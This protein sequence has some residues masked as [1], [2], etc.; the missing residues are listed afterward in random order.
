[1][2][3][4]VAGA[5]L[6][7]TDLADPAL[8]ALAKLATRERARVAPPA[9]TEGTALALLA[10]VASRRREELRTALVAASQR[11]LQETSRDRHGLEEEELREGAAYATNLPGPEVRA[12]KTAQRRA[13]VGLQTALGNKFHKYGPYNHEHQ[14]SYEFLKDLMQEV[15]SEQPGGARA[16]ASLAVAKLGSD[17]IEALEVVAEAQCLLPNSLDGWDSKRFVA[18]LPR[19]TDE[20]YDAFLDKCFLG[21][22]TPQDLAEH[23][24][25]AGI[26]PALVEAWKGG[27]DNL[28]PEVMSRLE[29]T[30]V[31]FASNSTHS[32]TS[33]C[34]LGLLKLRVCSNPSCRHAGSVATVAQCLRCGVGPLGPADK[35]K[36]GGAAQPD[37]TAKEQAALRARLKEAQAAISEGEHLSAGRTSPRRSGTEKHRR[38]EEEVREQLRTALGG[39][40]G[41]LFSI[42]AA[43]ERRE[44]MGSPEWNLT[45][46]SLAQ[47]NLRPANQRASMGLQPTSTDLVA[48]A[49]EP[50]IEDGCSCEKCRSVNDHVYRFKIQQLPEFLFVHGDRCSLDGKGQAEIQVERV[51][52][53][54]PFVS[55]RGRCSSHA[56]PTDEQVRLAAEAVAMPSESGRGRLVDELLARGGS[57]WRYGPAM[58]DG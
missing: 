28:P 11:A 26:S 13:I 55:P 18:G 47:R 27:T 39:L 12:L 45:L 21:T 6:V 40:R 48:A 46:D 5:F 54:A 32:V 20:P 24:L 33:L 22:V 16:L 9:E 57:V 14:D 56:R 1:M 19:R 23:Q 52:N 34:S 36:P 43:S 50:C 44:R 30:A 10:V 2:G 38:S 29:Q 51:I 31:E 41:L 3:A 8:V 4:E 37:D 53:L 35:A 58:Q 7:A 25:A 15:D 42:E 49:V 17:A